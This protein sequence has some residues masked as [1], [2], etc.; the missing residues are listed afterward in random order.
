[1]GRA[2]RWLKGLF[3]FTKNNSKGDRNSDSQQDQNRCS[4]DSQRDTIPQCA[5]RKNF[6]GPGAAWL[7]ANSSETEKDLQAK[8]AIAVAAAT[9]VAADAAV[10]A[11]R[12]AAAVAM[13]KLTHRD[14]Q[15]AAFGRSGGDERW[16]AAVQIQTV[17]R[18]YLVSGNLFNI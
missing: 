12:A 15:V 13:V 6:S 7:R 16:P 10:A 11:A 4:I 8:H 1:M 9:A 3:G 17:F 18:G 5:P 2:T 14:R